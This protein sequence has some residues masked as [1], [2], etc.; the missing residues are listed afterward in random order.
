MPQ[1][2]RDLAMNKG[3]SALWLALAFILVPPAVAAIPEAAGVPSL[4]PMLNEITPGVGNIAVRSPVPEASHN[5]PLNHPFF[6]R[7]FH[8]PQQPQRHTQATCSLLP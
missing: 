4:A 6:P 5:P 2:C 1:A 8:P 3:I 7:L